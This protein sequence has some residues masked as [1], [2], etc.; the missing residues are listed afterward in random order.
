MMM[1]MEYGAAWSLSLTL[2]IVASMFLTPFAAFVLFVL[3]RV[4]FHAPR[5]LALALAAIPVLLALVFLLRAIRGFVVTRDAIFVRHML[6]SSCE[7]LDGLISAQVDEAAMTDAKPMRSLAGGFG[8]GGW[9][10]SARFSRFRGYLTNK[11][12]LVVLKLERGVVVLSPDDP[13]AFV[14]HIESFRPAPPLEKPA[15]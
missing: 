15:R 14:R 6:W 8:T 5:W 3:L 2:R 13:D 9:F 1:G 7:P 12:R 10:W 11:R 4:S